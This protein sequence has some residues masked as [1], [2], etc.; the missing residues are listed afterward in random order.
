MRRWLEKDHPLVQP[1]ALTIVVRSCD[2]VGDRAEKCSRPLLSLT[3]LLDNSSM[4]SA[5]RGLTSLVVGKRS[6]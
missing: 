5:L 2:M 1:P 3:E 6:P 4:S